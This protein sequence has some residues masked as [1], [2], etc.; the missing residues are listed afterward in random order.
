MRST[1]EVSA[2][3]PKVELKAGAFTLLKLCMSELDADAIDGLL[4]E[5]IAKAPDFFRNT[6]IVID[7]TDS[8]VETADSDL[9]VAVGAIR[10]YGLVP[11]GV[12][13]GSKAFQEQARLL[14]LAVFSEHRRTSKKDSTK[15]PHASASSTSSVT[16]T[17]K[18]VDTPV[19]SGQRIYAQ[20]DLVLLAPVSS[21]AEVV[22]NGSIHAYT[23]IRGRVLAGVKGDEQA[24]I[25]CKD[26]RAELV[27][28]AGRYKV[29]EDL[30]PRFMG[31]LV[32]VTLLGDALIFKKL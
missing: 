15:K 30:E 11:V 29:S 5:R 28:I 17:T 9:A 13:G 6:P 20:G 25:F 24:A 10:G 32:R 23:S 22:A 1:T 16:A 21:G 4:C 3:G 2:E 27:S 12:R 14:E 26:L 31:R 18:V 7:L 8:D 19:R